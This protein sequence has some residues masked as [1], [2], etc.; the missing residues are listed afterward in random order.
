VS[1]KGITIVEIMMI[2]LQKG[3]KC[4]AVSVSVP[5][6]GDRLNFD[7]RLLRGMLV[8]LS[9]CRANECGP[10]GKLRPFASHPSECASITARIHTFV[11]VHL[12][13]HH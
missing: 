9:R 6:Q 2:A 1:V 3:P 12:F 4:L 11:L 8:R 5:T 13:E 10:C 7:Q